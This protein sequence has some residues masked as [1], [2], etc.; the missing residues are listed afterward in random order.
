MQLRFHE[1]CER[2]ELQC[3]KLA[4]LLAGSPFAQE[5]RAPGLRLLLGW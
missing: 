5:K 2:G 1:T 3:G 4:G